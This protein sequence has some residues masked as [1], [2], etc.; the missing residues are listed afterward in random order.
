[1]HPALDSDRAF[2]P[3][4]AQLIKLLAAVCFLGFFLYDNQGFSQAYYS[5]SL[6]EFIFGD[7]TEL[8]AQT[9]PGKMG[10]YFPEYIP[11]LFDLQEKMR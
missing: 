2:N 9:E 4:S 11:G 8:V 10:Q 1:M 3:R 6:T 7:K 5:I